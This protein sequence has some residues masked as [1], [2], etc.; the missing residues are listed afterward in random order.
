MSPNEPESA[1]GP[2]LQTYALSECTMNRSFWNGSGG[3]P[4]WATDTYSPPIR[5]RKTVT[6]LFRKFER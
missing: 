4:L 3:L 2:H 5:T 1:I 6:K